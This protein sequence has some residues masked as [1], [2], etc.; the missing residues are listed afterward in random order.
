MYLTG[1]AVNNGG[2]VLKWFAEKVLKE[3]LSSE[4]EFRSVLHD[5]ML[6][7]PGAEGLIFL[8]YISGERSPVWDENA[9]G[10]F[11]GLH[12][13]HTRA[14]LTRAVIEGIC[15]ALFD[16]LN[17]VEETTGAVEEI[18]LSGGVVQ[19]DEWAQL[20]ANITGK[21]IMVNDAADASALGAAFIGMKA[22][23]ILNDLKD[24]GSFLQEIKAFASDAAHHEVYKKY[25]EVYRELYG[26][27]KETF[28]TIHAIVN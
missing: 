12:S 16:V 8:P 4:A 7:K 27:L 1:G 14:H 2:N 3:D 10:V 21:K 11:M 28:D 13:T 6:T 25:F 17:A 18:Y 20:L 23:D 26:K 22:V 9:R 5:A 15:F 19:S 24:V